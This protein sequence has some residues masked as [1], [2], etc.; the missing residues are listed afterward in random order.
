MKH[1][2]IA[3]TLLFFS[4][5]Q[6][7]VIA[8]HF[9]QNGLTYIG[10]DLSFD[11]A[12][13]NTNI[14]SKTAFGETIALYEDDGLIFSGSSAPFQMT[15]SLANRIVQ[16]PTTPDVR[17]I[18]AY[19]A[20]AFSL[21][22][23][24][25]ATLEMTNNIVLHVTHPGSDSAQKF[26]FNST[27]NAALTLYQDEAF[28]G[29]GLLLPKGSE[30]NE[31]DLAGTYVRFTLGRTLSTSNVE[32]WGQ[33]ERLSV[34]QSV[35]SFDGL[36]QVDDAGQTITF[37]NAIS[38]YTNTVSGE[39]FID[40]HIAVNP[41]ETNTF[42]FSNLSYSVRSD[43][44]LA[45]DYGSDT[46]E[47]QLTRDG[48]LMGSFAGSTDYE[49]LAETYLTLAV[50]QPVDM[51]TTPVDSVYYLIELSEE[52]LG[53]SPTAGRNRNRVGCNYSYIYLQPDQTFHMRSDSWS[54][55]NRLE[56]FITDSTYF[57]ATNAPG[58]LCS[59]NQIFTE[60][61]DRITE[62]ESGTYTMA[63]NG[64]VTL[65]FENG[66]T[67]TAQLS[68]NGE[69]LV[70]SSAESK[71][72]S[73]EIVFGIGVRRIAPT[74]ITVNFEDLSMTPTGM[75]LTVAM[76]THSAVEGIYT[77][78]LSSSSWFFGDIIDNDTN[79]VVVVVDSE[80]TNV[81]KRCYSATFIPW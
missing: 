56:N 74:F 54:S 12:G 30:M 22:G 36:G 19:S 27:T 58:D 75:A 50:R 9:T 4:Y 44:R 39:D 55:E 81:T 38:E 52:F 51:P 78:D 13:V 1:K 65:L 7:C 29:L 26:C 20:D 37:E 18:N 45:L 31:S 68:E 24:M 28:A 3:A 34:E 80:A 71:E 35:M 14:I 63:N 32:S 76:P 59:A 53:N 2:T 72:N 64:I 41:P 73:D 16:P 62:L 8:Q 21:F 10:Y 49:S 77:D 60:N 46:L 40:T 47:G 15:R 61:S 66:D 17:V 43:G 79:E 57:I 48:N 11:G 33:L 42:L 70:Y 69:Y 25:F 23:F 6:F 67:A 5:L